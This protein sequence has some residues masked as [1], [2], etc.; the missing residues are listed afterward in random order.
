M[1]VPQFMRFYHYSLA[2]TLDE[3]AVSFFSLVNS[4]FRIKAR[5]NI[6]GALRVSLGMSGKEGRSTLKKLEKESQG[7]HGILQEVRNVKG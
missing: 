5:E 2:D 1:I 6:D 4:M 7:L 3:F